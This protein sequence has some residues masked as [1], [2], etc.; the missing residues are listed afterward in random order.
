MKAL[1][2]RRPTMRNRQQGI[3]LMGLIVGAV[4]LIFAA[5]LAMKLVPSYIE[6]F[7]VKKAMAGIAV[8]TRGR[9]ASVADIR[10]LAQGDPAVRQ[11][12]RVHRLHGVDQGLTRASLNACPAP[13]ASRSVSATDSSAPDCLSR[14]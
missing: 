4:V 1:F 2:D 11:H 13:R 3:T 5:I 7:A 8:D 6:F 14:R 10:R 12:R 9:G